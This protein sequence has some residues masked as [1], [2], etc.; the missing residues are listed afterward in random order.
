MEVETSNKCAS[1]Q[2]SRNNQPVA[3]YIVAEKIKI[4]WYIYYRLRVEL[5]TKVATKSLMTW[6]TLNVLRKFQLFLFCFRRVL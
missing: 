3:I 5:P 1:F 6:H 4:L 2:L